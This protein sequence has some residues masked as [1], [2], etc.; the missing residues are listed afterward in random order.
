[1]SRLHARYFAGSEA[2]FRLREQTLHR[3]VLVKR[4][5]PKVWAV[6]IRPSEVD[7]AKPVPGASA[8]AVRSH[9]DVSNDF[10]R[11]W[12]GPTMVYSSAMWAAGE[13]P[14]ELA[15]AHE[16]KID[17]FAERILPSGRAVHVLDVGCGWGGALRRMSGTRTIADAVGLTLSQAQHEFLLR[18]PISGTAIRLEDWQDHVPSQPY[19]AIVSFGAFEHFAQ[20]G[21]T[22][23]Q[24]IASYRRFFGSCFE[25]LSPGGRLALETIAHDDAP[26]TDRTRGRGPVGDFVLDLYPESLCPHLSEVVLGFEPYFEL[27]M[28]R[29]DADDFA[30]TF[31]AWSIRLRSHREDAERLVG[32]ETARRFR[33]YL[34]ACELQFRIRSITNYRLVLVRRPALRH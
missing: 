23:P 2:L 15:T 33:R 11:L 16:R 9:Y 21:S 22:G 25:W 7:H 14:G 29:S 8:A 6:K 24:R 4:P 32:T 20:D 28:L 30:R 12:L 19:D 3:V 5:Q 34:A 10:Y 31:R 17:F 27:D 1:V 26:D 13:G 18:S